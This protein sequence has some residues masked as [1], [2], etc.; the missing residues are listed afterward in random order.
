MSKDPFAGRE[1]TDGF[2]VVSIELGS[3]LSLFAQVYFGGH[4]QHPL[5]VNEQ[6]D[7]AASEIIQ[8]VDPTP[9][10]RGECIRLQLCLDAIARYLTTG[11]TWEQLNKASWWLRQAF[12]DGIQYPGYHL[13]DSFVTTEGVYQHIFVRTGTEDAVVWEESAYSKAGGVYGGWLEHK[14]LET[15]RREQADD[16]T[17][18]GKTGE[19]EDDEDGEEDGEEDSAVLPQ[20]PDE[21]GL[22]PEEKAS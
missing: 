5:G 15:I 21:S 11:G 8:W 2:H 16:D 3:S 10:Q 19:D 6:A 4:I 12:T 13:Y 17:I 7:D 14:D 18:W 1:P 22:D 20:L 9:E